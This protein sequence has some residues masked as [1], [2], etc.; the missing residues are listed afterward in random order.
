MSAAL[1]SEANSE[2]AAIAMTILQ[3]IRVALFALLCSESLRFLLAFSWSAL[4]G[5]RFDHHQLAPVLQRQQSH[6]FAF[7]HPRPGSAT[8][9]ART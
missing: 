5:R 8:L 7:I 3:F 2:A 6:K 4:R 1:E 9:A